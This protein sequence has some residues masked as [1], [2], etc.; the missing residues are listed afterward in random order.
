MSVLAYERYYSLSLSLS[1]AHT[2]THAHT[3]VRVCMCV[4]VCVEKVLRYKNVQ[5]GKK[6][7]GIVNVILFIV[8]LFVNVK[9]FGFFTWNLHQGVYVCDVISSEF[10]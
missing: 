2:H 10:F 5:I 8:E 1:L 4:C 6:T 3:Y 7:Q 9:R